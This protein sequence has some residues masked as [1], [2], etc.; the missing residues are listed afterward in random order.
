MTRKIQPNGQLL[1]STL[2]NQWSS[3]SSRCRPRA[4]KMNTHPCSKLC[5]MICGVLLLRRCGAFLLLSCITMYYLPLSHYHAAVLICG[6][7]ACFE[8]SQNCAPVSCSRWYHARQC[9]CMLWR[10]NVVC[11]EV[12]RALHC[13]GLQTRWGLC[14]LMKYF[15][16]GPP[17]LLL[18]ECRVM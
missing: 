12:N 10:L 6:L 4:S 3:C 17:I 11:S 16:R 18:S 1:T 9:D 7:N 2:C 8:G 15:W 14:D 13:T 5:S